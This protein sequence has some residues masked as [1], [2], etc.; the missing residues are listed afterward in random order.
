MK[1]KM[2]IFPSYPRF[3]KNFEV[4]CEASKFLDE[5]KIINYEVLLTIDG[6]ENRYT[7]DLMSKYENLEHV[8]FVGLLKKEELINLYEKVDCLIFPSKLETWDF[9]FQNLKIVVNLF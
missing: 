1:K 9:Q 5:K 4:I 2:F 8:K 3:F 6:T 7:H